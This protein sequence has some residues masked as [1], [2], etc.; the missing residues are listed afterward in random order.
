MWSFLTGLAASVVLAAGTYLV[1]QAGTVPMVE[2]SDDY[3]T[4]LN[5]VWEQQSPATMSVPLATEGNIGN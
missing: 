1:L 2:K 3:S 4:L 5:G